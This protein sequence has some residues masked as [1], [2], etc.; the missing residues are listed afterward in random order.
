MKKYNVM[1]SETWRFETVLI[2]SVEFVFP[3][4]LLMI[5]MN[6]DE[7]FCVNR[8]FELKIDVKDEMS[9]TQS[10]TLSAKFYLNETETLLSFDANGAQVASIVHVCARSL[11]SRLIKS[12]E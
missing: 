4:V 6:F 3:N 9:S 5:P 10:I 2:A 7:L 1:Q 8:R 12:L 11:A